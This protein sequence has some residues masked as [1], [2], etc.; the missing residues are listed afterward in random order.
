MNDILK[1]KLKYLKDSRVKSAMEYSLLA[2][3]KRL[4]PKLLYGVVDGFSKN[5][6]D[7]DNIACSIEMIHTYSLIHD[8][9]PSMDNDDY[10]RGM[11]TCHI[12]FDEATAILA[13]D[14]LLTEAFYLISSSNI[15]SEKIVKCISILSSAAGCNG[16]IYGQELDMFFKEYGD[17]FEYL[18]NVHKHKTG[19]LISAPL[20]MGCILSDK[21]QYLS[22]FEEI[23]YKMGLAFQIHDDILDYTCSEYELGKSNS[24]IKNNKLTSINT[25]GIEKAIELKDKLYDECINKLKGVNDFN[26]NNL[27]ELILNTKDRKK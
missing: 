10:R 17:D 27:I 26:S 4:R 7:L 24:D 13:G 18:K 1:E 2:G 19:M 3:G 15:E 8:D 22:L 20:K 12:E 23:G 25:I 14:G 21:E 5:I 16:M 6:E 9:L 11:K